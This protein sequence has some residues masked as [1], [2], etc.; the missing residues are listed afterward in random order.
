MHASEQTGVTEAER[1]RGFHLFK[2]FFLFFI[3]LA[4]IGLAFFSGYERGRGSLSLGDGPA[5]SPEGAI[6]LDKNEKAN[7]VDFGLFWK[8]WDILK[9]KFVD[10]SKLDAKQMLYGAIDGMLASTGD[11]YTTFFDPKE[12]QEFQEDITGNF[13][14]IG[15]EMGIKDD[16]LTVIAPLEDTPAARAG[17]MAGDKILKIDGETTSNIAL[18]EAVHRIRGKKGTEVTL[19]IFHEGDEETKDV[20]VKR[21]V[22]HVKS[23]RFE[24]KADATAY[25][26]VNR[27]GEETAAEFDQAVQQ[28]IAA[29]A[30]G[31]VIDLRNNPGGLL[32]SAVD[33]G[34][35][36]LPDRSVVVV[37]ENGKGVK[38]ELKTKGGDVLSKIPTAVL[39][40]EGSASASEILAGALREN[41][42]NVRLIGKKSFGKGSVQ[43]LVNVTKDAAVKITVAR[44]LTPKGNQINKVGIAPDDEVT[45]TRED[46][47]A[48]KDP[49]LEKALEWLK[50]QE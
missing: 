37:E 28:A 44:W 32:D 12:N 45:L 31:L 26:R 27:F 17:L 39:I 7:E 15:A 23:V 24:M 13:E 43:E 18:E 25:I 48:K 41:R 42:E 19:N 33:I 49:Q 9:D 47:A 46:V 29:K 34:S 50:D 35:F 20:V 11:P 6:I 8:V 4:L 1:E 21:D 10:K 3:V 2:K 40:N 36:L 22:I 5:I 30:H 38:H 16:V 14:G